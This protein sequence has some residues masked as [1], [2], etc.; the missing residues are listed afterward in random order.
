MKIPK[1]GWLAVLLFAVT[2]AL[3]S[4]ASTADF[5]QWDDDINIYSNE[6]IQGLTAENWRWIWTDTSYVRRYIPLGWLAWAVQY[7]L[8]GPNPAAFHSF[9]LLLHGLSAVLLFLIIRRL[10]RVR[11]A[12]EKPSAPLDLCA[13]FGA[14]V[15]ALHPLRVESVAWAS[16]QLYCQATTFLL[17][18]LFCYLR[19][20][21]STR[22]K[23]F[24]YAVSLFSFAASLLTYPIAL[25]WVFIFPV[26]DFF[27]LKRLALHRNLLRDR[28]SSRI[29]LEKFPFFL[30][31]GITLALTLLARTHAS[32]LWTTPVTLEKFGLAERLMQAFYVWAYFVWKNFLPLNL[33][34][35]YTSLFQIHPYDAGFITAA[36]F[37]IATSAF[38]FWQRRRWPAFFALWCCYLVVMVPML[39]L[40]EHPH[41]TNDRYGQLSALLLAVG[42]AGFVWRTLSDPRAMRLAVG[43]AMSCLAVL[44]LLSHEQINPWRNTESLLQHM[45]VN[46]GT[47]PYRYDTHNRLALWYSQKGNAPAAANQ[48]RLSLAVRPNQLSD[49][50]RLSM[51][52]ATSDDP[53][54]RNGELALDYARRA[55]ELTHYQHPVPLLAQAAA[56]AECGWY[57]QAIALT[58]KAR[59]IAAS[60]GDLK[61]VDLNENLLACYRCGGTFRDFTNSRKAE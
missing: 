24:W 40:T 48:Y 27:P 45:L 4:K 42:A 36:V 25:F 26:L 59:A 30:A 28:V 32:G 38:L 51:L 33:S 14:L 9:N 2:I 19:F 46:L 43:A 15:W 7:Q 8:F 53:A 6:H 55:C 50:T 47:D 61:L 37:V 57:D 5:V 58:E 21:E 17:V 11:F 41:F 31:A 60:K 44:A 12:I 20:C 1:T 49:L 22:R 3:F 35:L 16:G 54:A 10:L 29:L 52:L 18:S 23:W 34:P 13:A 39:G 56:Y